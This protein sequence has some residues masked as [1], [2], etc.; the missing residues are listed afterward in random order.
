[1]ND[2]ASPGH[3][4]P[5]GRRR[6]VIT[7]TGLVSC[8]GSSLGEVMNH[9]LEGR[10][11]IRLMDD[12]HIS[13]AGQI[14]P[15]IWA[16]LSHQY[17]SGQGLKR[18]DLASQYGYVAGMLALEEAG[19]DENGLYNPYRCACLI[20]SGLGA[21]HTM[22]HQ[23]ER[24]LREQSLSPLFMPAF[25]AHQGNALLTQ[26]MGWKGASYGIQAA[27]ATG[28]YSIIAAAQHIEQGQADLALCGGT[29]APLL[30]LI[31]EGFAACRALAPF[32]REAH[33]ASRPW[34]KERNGFVIAE[35]AGVLCL[36]SLEH[37]RERSATI[38]AEYVGGAW[39]SDAH[40]LTAPY[41][42]GDSLAH[43]IYRSYGGEKE[44][45]QPKVNCINAHATSTLLGDVAEVNALRLVFGDQLPS[46]PLYATKSLMGHSL[47]AAGA[48]E[49]IVSIGTLLRQEI[50][51]TTN[52]QQRDECMKDLDIV[53]QRRK[54]CISS[55]LSLSCGFGGHNSA[56]LLKRWE[57]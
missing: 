32:S 13:Y 16:K 19:I 30:P 29:E 55:V 38:L 6:V 34:D 23:G 14:N 18:C 31:V 36:E 56:I 50:H 1:M 53:V 41:P 51:P 43:C 27:C 49:A 7:G 9:L 15:T 21:V 52:L 2:V 17:L 10:S 42:Y 20:G 40:H 11:G 47:G 48:I 25:I 57:E 12:P 24:R 46:L 28:A 37:A 3:S 35:G 4:E 54:S 5:L 26:K 44:D 33:E 8:L 45:Q 39:T 22:Q